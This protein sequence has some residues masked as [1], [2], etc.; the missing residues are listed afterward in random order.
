LLVAPLLREA[1]KTR[2]SLRQIQGFAAIL[3]EKL[4]IAGVAA[5]IIDSVDRRKH[6]MSGGNRHVRQVLEAVQ[7]RMLALPN[8]PVSTLDK[9]LEI[10]QRKDYFFE[11]G[12]C[13]THVDGGRQPAV[14]AFLLASRF[15]QS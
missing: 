5:A 1:R 3:L 8:M 9:G 7:E 13:Q 11:N 6:R 12:G 10:I 14:G 4:M 2:D 15:D